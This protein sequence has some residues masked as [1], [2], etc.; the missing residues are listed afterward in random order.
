MSK[1]RTVRTASYSIEEDQL[2]CH[3]YV[4]ICQD[5]V[6]GHY[7]AGDV[8]WT[9]V[10]NAYHEALPAHVGNTR[11]LRSIQTR[12]QTIMT[13]VAKLRGCIVQVENLNPS[14]ASEQDIL[15]RAKELMAQDAKFKKGFK[16]DH[17]WPIV[18]D[19]EKF[20]VPSS[21]EASIASRKRSSDIEGSESQGDKS[22]GS[23]SF[24]LNLDDDFETQGLNN[25]R[26]TGRN[27]EK[28]KKK[29]FA[30]CDEY[31]AKVTEHNE[32]IEQMFEHSQTQL[33]KNYELEMLKAQNEVRQLELTELQ[34]ENK[35][36]SIDANSITDPIRREWVRNTELRIHAKRTRQPFGGVESSSQLNQYFDNLGGNGADL[37]DY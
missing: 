21:R 33:Q 24:C 17:V 3:V 16:F 32:K 28:K 8:F 22:I 12:M 20:K 35:I 15:D 10:M 30:E 7:Q 27:K 29:T 18:K 4:D 34:E 19:L 25:E 37:G 9:R 6:T 1:A 5:K 31:F 23:S 36:I 11:P 14:G 2:L 13:A 26:P